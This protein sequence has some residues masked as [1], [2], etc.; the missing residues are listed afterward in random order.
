MSRGVGEGKEGRGEGDGRPKG[1]EG[2]RQGRDGGLL[3]IQS[4]YLRAAGAQTMLMEKLAAKLQLR[5]C[6]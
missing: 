3:C 1:G 6:N 4:Q 5:C 2:S